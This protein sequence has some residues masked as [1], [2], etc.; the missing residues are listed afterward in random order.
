[1]S[2]LKLTGKM[3]DAVSMMHYGLGYTMGNGQWAILSKVLASA[4]E[5]TIIRHIANGSQN[6]DQWDYYTSSKVIHAVGNIKTNFC[7][8]HDCMFTRTLLDLTTTAARYALKRFLACDIG[9]FP[10][11]LHVNSIS[12]P[13]CYALLSTLT[14]M[15]PAQ[16]P[17]VPLAL[18]HILKTLCSN[19]NL[20]H[21]HDGLEPAVSVGECLM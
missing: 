10:I 18:L 17:S 21:C 15:H 3:T 20:Y 13:Y 4:A 5:V 2:G 12:L 14:S 7:T 16:Q 9:F 6:S 8:S 11:I 19:R 1:M